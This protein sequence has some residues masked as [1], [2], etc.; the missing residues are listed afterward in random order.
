MHEVIV[1]LIGE[2]NEGLK[3]PL[4]KEVKSYEEVRRILDNPE[5]VKIKELQIIDA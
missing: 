3:T 1:D 4:M 2:L 5:G